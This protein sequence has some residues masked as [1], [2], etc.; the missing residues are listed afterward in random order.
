MTSDCHDED[1]IS[2]AFARIALVIKFLAILSTGI[3]V[4][5]LY[6]QDNN[7]NYRSEENS[8]NNSYS[9]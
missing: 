8:S 5:R 2:S 4:M 7:E 9:A 3:R 6:I 1:A